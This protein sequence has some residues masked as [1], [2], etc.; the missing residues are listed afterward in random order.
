ME[1]Y[2]CNWLYLYF[3]EKRL[4]RLVVTSLRRDTHRRGF[5]NAISKY[6]EGAYSM[7]VVVANDAPRDGIMTLDLRFVNATYLHAC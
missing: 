3:K 7:R 6:L 4:G 5:R 1:L 2:D